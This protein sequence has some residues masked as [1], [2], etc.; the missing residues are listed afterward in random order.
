M[1][2]GSAGC[3]SQQCLASSSCA[4]GRSD[5]AYA[6]S[7]ATTSTQPGSAV[8]RASAAACG[9]GRGREGRGAA[10]RL[11]WQ[12]SSGSARRS[13]RAAEAESA[14]PAAARMPQATARAACRARAAHRLPHA[15]PLGG[16]VRRQRIEVGGVLRLRLRQVRLRGL[17]ANWHCAERLE[18]LSRLAL[19][20]ERP[21]LCSERQA[22]QIDNQAQLLLVR[23]ARQQRRPPHHLGRDAS[24]AP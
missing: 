14:V 4:D 22:E 23:A 18:H 3:A 24:H 8:G 1:C 7:R 10:R 15:Q 20:A 13:A 21:E 5:G 19:A 11:S 6:S 9:H 2:A 17:Q 16:D 12:Q